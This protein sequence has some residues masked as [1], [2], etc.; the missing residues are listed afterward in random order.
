MNK[1]L[2]VPAAAVEEL[3]KEADR[4]EAE[5]QLGAAVRAL[6]GSKDA[7]ARRLRE[8]AYPLSM[9]PAAALPLTMRGELVAIWTTLTS[10]EPK[11]PN[12]LAHIDATLA[13]MRA[14]ELAALA[15]RIVALHDVVTALASAPRAPRRWTRGG[16][17]A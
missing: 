5:R 14:S 10:A 3:Q 13:G 2:R 9:V 8:A 7:F 12:V 17:T 4:L 6:I 1:R 15:A 16:R 11:S